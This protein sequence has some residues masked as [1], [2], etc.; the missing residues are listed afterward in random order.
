MLRVWMLGNK[1]QIPLVLQRISEKDKMRKFTYT[2]EDTSGAILATGTSG[3]AD[4]NTAT[5]LMEKHKPTNDKVISA[6]LENAEYNM[7]IS[8]SDDYYISFKAV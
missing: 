7:S 6:T 1:K 2:I 3:T 8:N 4:A 5:D